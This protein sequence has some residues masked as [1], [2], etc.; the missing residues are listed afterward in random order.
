MKPRFAR[1]HLAAFAFAFALACAP[2]SARAQQAGCD[3]ARPCD[4]AQIGDYSP[5]EV[6]MVRP[7]DPNEAR[8]KP[9]P[10]PLFGLEEKIRVK[11]GSGLWLA[12]EPITGGNVFL[13]GARS[14]VTLDLKVGF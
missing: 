2:A 4:E 11:P 3:S 7:A 14:K 9:A 13:N 12:G 5:P 6:A 1:I 8:G 10:L